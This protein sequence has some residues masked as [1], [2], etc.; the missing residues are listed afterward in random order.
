MKRWLTK[1]I[2]LE[3]RKRMEMGHAHDLILFE[4]LGK[5]LED[6]ED[7]RYFGKPSPMWWYNAQNEIK[8]EK[9]KPDGKE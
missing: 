9:E 8:V 3:L 7:C 2:A 5:W 4:D 6:E 1:R